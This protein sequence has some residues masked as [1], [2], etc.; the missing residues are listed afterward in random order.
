MNKYEFFTN[1]LAE[2]LSNNRDARLI[3]SYKE[4]IEHLT[5]MSE[6][7]KFRD[8]VDFGYIEDKDAEPYPVAVQLSIN[9]DL[10]DFDISAV[11]VAEEYSIEALHRKHRKSRRKTKVRRKNNSFVAGVS[12][13]FK[14]NHHCSVRREYDI[15]VGKSNFT[16]KVGSYAWHY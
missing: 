2:M 16:H 9:F 8:A 6:C 15:P 1:E 14:G 10:D 5:W 13:G 3:L 7:A 4:Q 12:K 11:V